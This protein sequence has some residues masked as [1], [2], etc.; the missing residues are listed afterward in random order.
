MR[1]EEG[2]ERHMTFHFVV[3]RNRD[4]WNHG[5]ASID[6][7]R[8][9]AFKHLLL[10]HVRA[11]ATGTASAPLENLF[12]WSA[13]VIFVELLLLHL[14]L[15]SLLLL[16]ESERER[17]AA[18]RQVAW[19]HATNVSKPPRASHSPNALRRSRPDAVGFQSRQQKS[20]DSAMGIPKPIWDV[21]SS[22]FASSSSAGDVTIQYGMVLT[23]TVT[24]VLVWS[25]ALSFS[26]NNESLGVFAWLAG[27]VHVF[28][29]WWTGWL[30]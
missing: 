19:H 10:R 20:K 8:H 6:E 11:P 25:V 5:A 15:L 9:E 17:I 2:N 22:C 1:C 27:M 16:H 30:W 18:A 23:L 24:A 4:V 13:L 28:V 21:N 26:P 14:L 29:F 7:P 3:R 12:R